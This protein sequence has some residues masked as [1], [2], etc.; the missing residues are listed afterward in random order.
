MDKL[1]EMNMNATCLGNST[2]DWWGGDYQSVE[3]QSFVQNFEDKQMTY[4]NQ[5]PTAQKQQQDAL[6]SEKM[7]QDEALQQLTSKVNQLALHSEMLENIITQQYDFLSQPELNSNEFCE[8]I[9]LRN[10]TQ[11]EDQQDNNGQVL[12]KVADEIDAPTKNELFNQSE[13]AEK[14]E[15][16]KKSAEPCEPP[17]FIQN[18]EKTHQVFPLEPNSLYHVI[19]VV[20][21]NDIGVERIN[22]DLVKARGASHNP[23]LLPG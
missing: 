11:V 19:N 10:E 1:D 17:S 14:E 23:H 13:E 22:K 7:K 8:T 20:T 16:K 9:T 5:M 4:F 18:E 12:E 2:Y 6:L 15:P 3:S 21:I